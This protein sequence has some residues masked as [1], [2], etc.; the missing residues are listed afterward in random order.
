MAVFLRASPA[1]SISRPT[2]DTGSSC[3]LSCGA[4]RAPAR[5][6][7]TPADMAAAYGQL[8]SSAVAVVVVCSSSGTGGLGW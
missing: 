2:Y 1:T 5:N 7:A 6:S 4:H 3:C 8:S